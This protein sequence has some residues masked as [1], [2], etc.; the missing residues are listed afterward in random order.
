MSPS[1]QDRRREYPGERFSRK[2]I[3]QDL[4]EVAEKLK[5]EEFGEGHMEQG[6]NQIELYRH[7]NT[8]VSFFVLDEGAH[9]KEHTVDDG[10]VMI[11]VRKGKI[12]FQ[13]EEAQEHLHP[14]ENSIIILEPG[15]AHSVQAEQSSQILV[16]II[17]D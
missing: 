15:V 11:Q 10:S 6:H 8:T 4:D 13:T 3:E 14:E 2:I 12:C 7:G 16:T 9:L 5:E 1:E 17:R